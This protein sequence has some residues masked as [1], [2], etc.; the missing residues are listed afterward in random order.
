MELLPI[1]FL[2]GVL[3]VL[4]PCVLPLLPVVLAGSAVEPSRRASFLIIGS[5][6]VSVVLFTLLIKATTV[7]L[8]V[9]SGV[10]LAIS[11]VL[12][13]FV[14]ATL[15][16]PAGWEWL[17]GRLRFQSAAA[18]LAHRSGKQSGTARS[19]LLGFSLG[20][21]FTSCSPT[22]GLILAVVLPASLVVG[23]ADIIAYT[24]GLS[25]VMLLAA[26]GGRKI[27][28]HLGWAA[29]PDG[30]FRRGLGVA[31]LIIGL[32]I[33]SGQVRKIEAWLIDRGLLGSVVLEQGILDSIN[34]PTSESGVDI[35]NFLRQSFPR[36]DWS[37]A[38]PAVANALSGGPSKDGIPAIDEPHFIP[39]SSFT[40]PDSVQAL[41][42][43]G[44]TGVKAY[45][46]NILIWHEIVNDTVDGTPVA[47]TFCP[48][49][50]SAV[51]FERVLPDGGTTTFGVSGG[52]LESNM[53]MFD[54]ASETLWQ[55]STGQSL[56]GKH[57]GHQLPLHKFQ[58]LTVGETKAQFPDALVLSD[59]TG[60][61]RD[62]SR[63]PYAG[64]EESEGFYFS[65]SVTDKRYPAKDIFVAFTLNGTPVAAPWLALEN[66]RTYS[67]S[68]DGHSV[69]LSKADNKLAVT[70]P[71]GSDIPF[72]FEM[73]F[74]WAVQHKDAGVVLDPRGQ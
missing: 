67:H 63:N 56:A 15:T 62:Y 71:D 32:L 55:Q 45:P 27:T 48:L 18:S 9:P 39:I 69:T 73:W 59:S 31:L 57:F 6:A 2:A 3:T 35:P 61:G 50:G 21:V 12:V 17:S 23:V 42:I 13:A 58:L 16:F 14:G 47:V 36:T 64:Y 46:Y 54:R 1:A 38:D 51:V 52:L 22:Y 8:A 29:D 25:V 5:L 40:H 68:V 37:R 70:G 60:Y 7:L 24:L 41:V 66:G 65:P 4:S 11:G 49:C 53:I 43:E 28:R 19:I 33:A 20:P 74:S 44:R 30:K 34:E 10:W 26:M 72:Y